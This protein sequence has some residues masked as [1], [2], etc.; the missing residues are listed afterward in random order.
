ML[1]LC[2]QCCVLQGLREGKHYFQPEKGHGKSPLANI[3]PPKFLRVLCEPAEVSHPQ[4]NP[5]FSK[6]LIGAFPGFLQ[7]CH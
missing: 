2:V 4:K 6:W 5:D 7:L 1:E 3:D